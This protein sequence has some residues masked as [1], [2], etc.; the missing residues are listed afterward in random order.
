MSDPTAEVK[1][2]V[3]RWHLETLTFPTW[4]EVLEFEYLRRFGNINMFIVGDMIEACIK[5]GL[6]H[7]LNWFERVKNVKA[8]PSSI[9][10]SA[11]KHYQMKHGSQ[12]TWL[13]SEI[14]HELLNKPSE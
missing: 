2:S 11:V 5:H 3:L 9:F 8:T 6:H 10:G 14:I 13:T 1:Q 12:D 4:Q 7:A